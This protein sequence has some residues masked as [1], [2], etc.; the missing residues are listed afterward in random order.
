M[1]MGPNSRA[2]PILPPNGFPDRLREANAAVEAARNSGIGLP[3]ALAECAFIYLHTG[4]YDEAA[5]AAHESL[6]CDPH[7]PAGVDAHLILGL[8]AAETNSLDEA[9]QHFHRAAQ[10]A[11]LTGNRLGLAR[12]IHHRAVNIQFVRGKFQLALS[13]MEE[14]HSI[15]RETQSSGWS[16]PWLRAYIYILTGDRRRAR[17]ALDE[18]VHDVEPATW[19]AGAYYYLWASLCIDEEELDRAREY[20]RLCLR[21]A[22]QTGSPDLNLWARIQQARFYRKLNDLPTARDWAEDAVRMARSMNKS[23]LEGQALLEWA[24]NV[25]PVDPDGAE[26]AVSRAVSLF[27]ALPAAYDL[28]LAQYFL[29]LWANPSS[30]EGVQ[31]W[32]DFANGVTENGYAFL[33]E[34]E[35]EAAFPLLVAHL[36]GE[37]ARARTCAEL[38]LSQ[39]SN[40][41]PPPLRIVCLGGFAVWKGRHL[42]PEKA[43]NRRKAGELFRFLLLQPTRSAGRDAIL[44]AL[45][46]DRGLDSGFDLLHQSTS[47]LRRIL[48]SDLPDKFPSRYLS[49]EGETL[50]LVLPPGSSVDYE[51]LQNQLTPAVQSMDPEKI[52]AALRRYTGDLL[53]DDRYADWTEEMRTKLAESRQAALLS[54]TRLLLGQSQYADALDCVRQIIRADPWDE[55]AVLLGMQCYLALNSVPHALR[56]FSRLEQTLHNDLGIEPRQDLRELARRLKNR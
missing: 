4:M 39:L 25:H 46:P 56:L 21:I 9:D 34:K 12:A 18:M 26:N 7:H 41:A 30:P 54:L 29:A 50:T 10:T 15:Y 36:R 28:T 35:Q 53:P 27:T 31:R 38:L 2:K 42:I 55:E 49:F 32:L 52:Q 48:E 6:A 37:D 40:V 16:M 44:E 8:C 17:Q 5:L 14:A 47:A 51:N 3:D 45:W 33:L 22:T 20:L 11:H 43:W 23:L 13:L 1:E 19:V 24:Q